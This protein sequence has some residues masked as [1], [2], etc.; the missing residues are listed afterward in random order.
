MRTPG[1]HYPFRR[2]ITLVELLVVVSIMLLLAVVS[3]PTMRPMLA[4]RQLRET[5]RAVNS[6][7]A[8]AQ[9]HAI[10][11]GR[12]AGVMFVR[13]PSLPFA[14]T[15]LEHV[16]VPAPFAGT[17]ADAGVRIQEWTSAGN[18][19]PDG[20]VVLKVRVRVGDFAPGMIRRG[21]QMQLNNQGPWFVIASDES[22]Y[23]GYGPPPPA[24]DADPSYRDFPVDGNGFIDFA[25]TSPNPPITS[26]P[27]SDGTSINNWINNY[28]LTLV[29][30]RQI[31]ADSPWVDTTPASP[32]AFVSPVPV[33]W[34]QS[35]PFQVRRAP[36]KSPVAPL[37]LTNGY[38]VDLEC[39]GTEAYP[40]AF[41]PTDANANLTDGV[42]DTSPVLVLF[43]PTG[44]LD[45]L[46]VGFQHQ[47]AVD[48]VYLM[49]G[50]RDRVW[51][52]GPT[53]ALGD[54]LTPAPEDRLHNWQDVRNSWLA[55]NS[56]TGTITSAEVHGNVTDPATN[57]LMPDSVLT[58][59]ESVR[60]LQISKGGR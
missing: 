1:R 4:S 29:L 19:W 23:A 44:A 11:T 12:S 60:Q 55:I 27:L 15:R 8:A 20:A 52:D 54:D 13:D 26:I 36:V 34:S 37:E 58:S 38:V 10:Q 5:T 42:Q 32:G 9:I 40:N 7:I 14:A 39:S 31:L 50:R 28:V 57:T 21:D 18:Y 6:Y 51:Q 59:R 48:P 43:S 47:F 56:K 35:V 33:Q 41:A 22:P 25:P 24:V 16:E 30:P 49:I 2:G 45:S 53:P 3:I 17:T 46:Y